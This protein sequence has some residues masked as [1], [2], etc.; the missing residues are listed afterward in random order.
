M[1]KIKINTFAKWESFTS[2]FNNQG[3]PLLLQIDIENKTDEK[4]I[5]DSICFSIKHNFILFKTQKD[6]LKRAKKY[7]INPKM[8]ISLEIDV[9][10]LFNKYSTN[11]KFNIKIVSNNEIFESDIVH[12]GCIENFNNRNYQTI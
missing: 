7:A 2:V 9:R 5:I 8:T 6:I 3:A 11:K 1:T 10:Y 12:L 4:V